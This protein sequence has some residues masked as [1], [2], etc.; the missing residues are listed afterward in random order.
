MECIAQKARRKTEACGREKEE[1]IVGVPLI[2]LGQNAN[3]R[4]HFIGEC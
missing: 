1:K 3:R 2:S 4:C